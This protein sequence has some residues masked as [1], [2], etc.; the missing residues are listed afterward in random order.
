MW[1]GQEQ[2]TVRLHRATQQIKKTGIWIGKLQKSI[3]NFRCSVWIKP[4][5]AVAVGK[6]PV[7]KGK[8]E[9]ANHQH[10]HISCVSSGVSDRWH[11]NR[12]LEIYY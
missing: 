8:G 3:H 9:V 2:L 1:Q 4:W 10:R 11:P 5:P 12:H 7:N 6:V